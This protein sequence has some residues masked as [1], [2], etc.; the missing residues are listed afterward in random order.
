MVTLITLTWFFWEWE[1][2][3]LKKDRLKMNIR[4]YP[5]TFTIT[6]FFNVNDYI[7]I[8]LEVEKKA[9]QHFLL[10]LIWNFLLSSFFSLWSFLVNSCSFQNFLWEFSTCL[11]INNLFVKNNTSYLAFSRCWF[12]EFSLHNFI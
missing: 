4:K 12:W 11:R 5:H 2:N 1:I 9:H 10:I 3:K 6:S 7:I 8:S